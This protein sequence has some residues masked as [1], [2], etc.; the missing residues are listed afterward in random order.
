MNDERDELGNSLHLEVGALAIRAATKAIRSK[1]DNDREYQEKSSRGDVVTTLDRESEDIILTH[2]NR[3][4]P[5]DSVDAEEGGMYMKN[6]SANCWY[7]DPLDGSH[8][9]LIGIHIAGIALAMYQDGQPV[10]ALASDVFAQRTLGSLHGQ[11]ALTENCNLASKQF[12]AAGVALQQG[13]AV[14]RASLA[15]G[16]VR[17]TL[18]SWYPRVL[19][20]W[21][22]IVDLI[23]MARGYLA[24]CVVLGVTGHERYAILPI[25][26]AIGFEVIHLNGERVEE[27]DLPTDYLLC[28][29]SE[30]E[31]LLS[32]V[33][34]W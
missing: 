3:R 33:S 18:E 4:F 1:V 34:G 31:R 30:S 25:A 8:N 27:R 7:V 15:L 19:Y 32:A 17:Q 20:T 29:K 12:R 23:L 22:P 28:W 5:H 2:L 9:V 26:R 11:I 14:D 13:Y 16:A 24:G 6:G 10:V 21:S